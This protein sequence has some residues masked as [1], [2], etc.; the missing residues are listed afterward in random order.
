VIYYNTVTNEYPRYQGDLELLGWK[1]GEPLPENWV[2]VVFVD[3]PQLLE[4]QTVEQLLPA[5]DA[6]GVW[7]MQWSEPWLLTQ[8]EVDARA[9]A[10]E[11]YKA[12]ESALR[13]SLEE[14]TEIAP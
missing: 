2:E 12:W 10:R 8:E 13:P 1:V 14:E 5:Q 11:A 7:H 3:M 9:A 4:N 6:E